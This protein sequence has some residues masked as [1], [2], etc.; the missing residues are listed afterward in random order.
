MAELNEAFN[1]FT[2]EDKNDQSID[3]FFTQRNLKEEHEYLDQSMNRK[4][5][6]VNVICNFVALTIPQYYLKDESKCTTEINIFGDLGYHF[7][8][9]LITLQG[10]APPFMIPLK[11]DKKLFVHFLYA[12]KSKNPDNESESKSIKEYTCFI[13]VPKRFQT[14]DTTTTTANKLTTEIDLDM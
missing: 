11:G 10:R 5:K 14:V 6:E 3:Y 9:T 7:K 1:G 4:N 2:F 12:D 8:G 13:E